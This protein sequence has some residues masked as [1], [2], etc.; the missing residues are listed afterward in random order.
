[1]YRAAVKQ[2]HRHSLI[3]GVLIFFQNYLVAIITFEL[4]QNSHPQVF[5]S[6]FHLYYYLKKIFWEG[7]L[8][9][10]GLKGN[11]LLSYETSPRDFTLNFDLG[12]EY[13]KKTKNNK[14]KS[15]A[16]ENFFVGFV[17]GG[18]KRLI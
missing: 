11:S 8:N 14:P 18:D 10:G 13:I 3:V 2:I 15:L 7:G 12:G 4:S 16:D 1:M 17:N 5:F 6:L 9:G